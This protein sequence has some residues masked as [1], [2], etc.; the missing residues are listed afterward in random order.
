M[1]CHMMERHYPRFQGTVICDENLWGFEGPPNI[2]E[3]EKRLLDELCLVEKMNQ[4][5][6]Y[7]NHL[8]QL[9]HIREMIQIILLR[10]KD[11]RN[12]ISSHSKVIVRYEK[13]SEQNPQ[14]QDKYQ[15]VISANNEQVMQARV[16]NKKVPQCKQRPLL[17]QLLKSMVH[18]K[19]FP[20][21]FIFTL[22]NNL[23]IYH[24]YLLT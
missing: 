14:N 20:V 8:D 10:I 6:N 17:P 18:F 5:V 11:L 15:W 1:F 21:A 9:H 16:S 3:Q 7:E 23:T 2:E 19:I 22:K 24:S 12:K 4:Y 13:L